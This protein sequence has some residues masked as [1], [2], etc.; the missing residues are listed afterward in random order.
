LTS[1]GGRKATG[2][3]YYDAS[4][5][6]QVQE[7]SVVVLA[8]WS[9][10]N[11]RLLL[12][13]ATD[14]HVNGL[15]NSSGLVG[16]YLM[17]HFASGTS[18][19]FDEDLQPFMGTIAGQYFSYDLYDKKAHKDKGAFGS[20]F[21]VAGAAQ[22]YSA[23]GGVANARPDL[24]GA[25]LGTFMKRAARGYTRLTAFAEEMP[26]VENRIELA[27]DKDE[28]GMPLGKITHGFND[29]AVA[30]FNANFDKGVEIAKA[31]NAKEIWPN[32]GP[33]PT[34]HLMGGTIMGNGAADSVTI[35]H[36]IANIRVRHPEARH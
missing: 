14:K 11:P 6:K 8:A 3:E 15:A 30:L 32:K 35:T 26:A 21:T 13:S 25:A 2:V 18:A 23:L 16:K 12:N 19:M 20:T 22:R 17:A 28:F 5:Q 34:I 7:A 36:E 29:D 33:M 4:K 31:T 24:F 1:V 10:Q 27:S 9:A